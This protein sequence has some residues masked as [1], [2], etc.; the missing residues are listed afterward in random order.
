MENLQR[1][2][3]EREQRRAI[4]RGINQQ[5]QLL[6]KSREGSTRYGTQLFKDYAETVSIA[7]DGLLSELLV[8]PTKA[9]PHFGAWP[10]LLTFCDRGPRSIAVIAVGVVV[11]RISQTMTKKQ[12]GSWIGRALFDEAKALQ[13]RDQR[14]MNLLKQ[15]HRHFG[16]RVVTTKALRQLG[17]QVDAWTAKERTEVGMLLVE[18]IAAN[19]RLIEILPGK[20]PMVKA[21]SEAW[22]V[23]NANPPRPLSIRMLPSLVPPEPWAGPAR[24]GRQL[25]TSRR[26]M[27][28]DHITAES[29]APVLQVVNRVEQ[30]Q[31]VMDPWMVQL[32]REAWDAGI[33]K[34][35]PVTR[36]PSDG[37]ANPWAAA[38][39]RMKIETAIRQAEEV[40]GLP[41]WLEH[42][43]DFRGR[44]YCSSRV[45]GHQGP[46]Y[47][48][49]VISFGQAERV[50]DDGF[51]ELL[52]A[53]AGHYG[54][55]R[56]S[57][58]ER[59][60]WG[61]DHLPQIQRLVESP[62]DRLE[63][64]RDAK[65]PWQFL[66]TAKALSGGPDG[67]SGCPV[68]YDQTCSGMGIIAALTRDRK[69]AELTNVIGDRRLDLYSHILEKLMARLRQDLDGYD[70][71]TVGLAE[72]W[73]KQPLDRALC[74]GPTMC[75]VYGSK[76]WGLS[77]QILEWLEEKNPNAQLWEWG[78][79]RTKPSL[80]LSKLMGEVIKAELPSCLAMEAWL[81][82]VSKQVV[83]KKGTPIRWTSPMGFPVSL[84]VA[85]DELVKAGTAIHGSRR[86]TSVDSDYEPGE[87]SA[88]QTSAGITANTVHVFDAALVHAVL[89]RGGQVDAPVLSNHD[90]F[91]TTPAHAKWLHRTLHD[92]L[93][94][95]Y[96]PDWLSALA[97][98][99]GGTSKARLRK[100]PFVYTLCP[101]EIGQNP[102][103]F[104]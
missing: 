98:E 67:V 103:C 75:T 74:K 70:F 88:R 17:V 37:E 57:W 94:A 33:R 99:V 48:K 34:L 90:C 66:Q 93:G 63:L 80:Y 4:E 91:C 38:R 5:K 87:L 86:M 44:L 50:G 61:R 25:V 102:Y 82:D 21:T 11:D 36:E 28:M 53:A 31:L 30:Q 26:P 54:L 59:R 32:Q 7:I 15:V 42:D 23:I 45:N 43:L 27:A 65:D 20:I 64:W 2:R 85:V 69:L 56:S 22:A 46:D 14:G 29:L 79:Q 71:A 96:R 73:L 9:G 49:A 35:F 101:G 10:L 76:T 81:R 77:E 47:S 40:A 39:T 6:A 100:P 97:K 55:G 41:I 104:S 83:G 13:V 1:Q 68:R 12:L 60:Q 84:G 62:L 78:R 19:T 3:R 58:E 92:E 51:E 18:V 72:F 95:L 8:N 89:A 24:N 16:R 52:A